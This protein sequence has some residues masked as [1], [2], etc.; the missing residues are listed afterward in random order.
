MPIDLFSASKVAN[1]MLDGSEAGL[2]HLPTP[3]VGLNFLVSCMSGISPR[4]YPFLES[5]LLPI[6]GLITAAICMHW[7]KWGRRYGARHFREAEER[8]R[9]AQPSRT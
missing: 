8:E 7:D 2:Y 6:A 3:D 5:C 4:A 9:A 1:A